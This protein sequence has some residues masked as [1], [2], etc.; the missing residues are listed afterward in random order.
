[1][2]VVSRWSVTLVMEIFSHARVKKSL[3]LGSSSLRRSTTITFEF[4]SSGLGRLSICC[5]IVCCKLSGAHFNL[6]CDTMC[7]YRYVY[8]SSVYIYIFTCCIAA[9]LFLLVA[10]TRQHCNHKAIWIILT[11]PPLQG[12]QSQHVRRHRFISTKE[13]VQWK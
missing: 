6:Q 11:S 5:M 7:T 8:N 13:G 3:M 10:S 2:L 12:L 4:T 1:M 9:S